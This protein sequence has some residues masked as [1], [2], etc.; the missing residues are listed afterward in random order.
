MADLEYVYLGRDNTIDLLLK[1]D[2]T[3]T[4]LA[5]VT[6]I[7]AS[8]NNVLISS[9]DN[10]A[11]LITWDVDGY[12]TGEIRI[13]VGGE[14]IPGGKYNK[15]PIIVYDATNTTGVHWGYIP[16]EVIAE[17]EATAPA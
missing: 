15:V 6:K 4:D 8:F 7:T 10:E 13:A 1:A 2:G 11:G 17:D 14:T 12:D 5:S 16:V 3:A 9:T